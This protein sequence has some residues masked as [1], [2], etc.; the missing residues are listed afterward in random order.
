MDPRAT[1]RS[2]PSQR[3]GE[4]S[5]DPQA[6]ETQRGAP[7]AALDA[8]DVERRLPAVTTSR[9]RL[10]YLPA[11]NDIGGLDV[12]GDPS[13]PSARRDPSR[14]S[15][16]GSRYVLAAPPA[17]LS[18]PQSGPMPLALGAATAPQPSTDVAVA[19]REPTLTGRL[20]SVAPP[21]VARQAVHELGV[22]AGELEALPDRLVE[23]GLARLHQRSYRRAT[24]AYV[25]L[26]ERAWEAVAEER[27]EQSGA[28][29]EYRA[30]AIDIARQITHMQNEARVVTATPDFRLSRRRPLF[31]RRRAR[32]ARAGLAAWMS[33]VSTPADPL[34]MGQSLF[35]LRGYVGLAN[36]SAV[37]L[38]LFGALLAGVNVAG[39]L[40][41]IGL[42]LLQIPTILAA[43]AAL[44]V[45]LAFGALLVAVVWMLALLLTV[46][47]RAPLRLQLGATLYTPMRTIR[48]TQRGSPALAGLLR[49]WGGLTMLGGIVA[50]GGALALSGLWLRDQL[51]STP[52]ADLIQG[53]QLAGTGLVVLAAPAGAACLAALLL[54]ALPLLLVDQSRLT[55]ELVGN[56]SW[57]PSARRSVLRPTIGA[58]GFLTGGLLIAVYAAATALGLA[59]SSHALVIVA[60]PSFDGMLTWRAALLLLAAVLP[61]LLLVELPYRV[62]QRRWQRRWLQNLT[63]RRAELESHMR[64][65]SA[66]DPRSGAQDASDENLRAMQYDL[67]LLQF[68]R[69]KI[70]EAERTPTAPFAWQRM[71]VLLALGIPL[72][73]VVDNIALLLTHLL[74]NAGDLTHLLGL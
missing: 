33:G 31:W 39:F 57:I 15:G 5:A 4:G 63:T 8:G 47:G 20:R 58:L 29:A 46:A 68:Y 36:A 38:G 40:L 64:R 30:Q 6:G 3:P 42:V 7:P 55:A 56:P 49:G 2:R 66:A 1:R 44:A 16:R 45:A 59:D 52:P 73:I 62:G 69:S 17:A 28:E 70:E 60:S 18:A 21:D 10:P 43:N 13:L 14:D 50:A 67:V 12:F 51:P 65:L 22:L 9:Q 19:A 34:A 26:A 72:A 25:G 37:E 32:L 24:L 41:A 48:N 61:Y 35:Q 11:E 71:L 74:T 23:S 27:L 53:S 54:V